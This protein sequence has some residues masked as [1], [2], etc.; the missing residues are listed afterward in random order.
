MSTLIALVPMIVLTLFAVYV[1][2]HPESTETDGD[3]ILD[4]RVRAEILAA[5]GRQ[6]RAA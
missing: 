6:E 4:Y 3:S 2:R 5:R 1:S